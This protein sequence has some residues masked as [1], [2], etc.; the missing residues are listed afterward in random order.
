MVSLV[1]LSL[2]YPLALASTFFFAMSLSWAV[3][4]L[5]LAIPFL[6]SGL[7][8]IPVLYAVLPFVPAKLEF[9]ISI[10]FLVATSPFFVGPVVWLV[11]GK[12][13]K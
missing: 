7:L 2:A 1:F 12:V 10:V 5:L 6:I 13:D 3:C 4:G 8:Y 11:R 9:V